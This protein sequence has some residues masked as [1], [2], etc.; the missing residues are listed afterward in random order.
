MTKSNK[1]TLKWIIGLLVLG[2]VIFH[3]YQVAHPTYSQ[4]YLKGWDAEV[5]WMKKT[6]NSSYCDPNTSEGSGNTCDLEYNYSGANGWADFSSGWNDAGGAGAT[7]N[8]KQGQMH[9]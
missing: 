3:Y 1:K 9:N 4:A 2:V 5:S 6:G 7:S 8:L